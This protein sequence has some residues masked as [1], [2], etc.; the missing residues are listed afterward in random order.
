MRRLGYHHLHVRLVRKDQGLNLPSALETR[1]IATERGVGTGH[2]SHHPIDRERLEEP[3]Q[4]DEADA[5]AWAL[6]EWLRQG[7][8]A[9]VAGRTTN[10]GVYAQKRVPAPPL[11]PYQWSLVC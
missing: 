8:E 10:G 3:A 7:G 2:R 1:R 11:T 4:R 6:R 5:A 9:K